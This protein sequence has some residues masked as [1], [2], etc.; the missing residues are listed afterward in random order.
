MGV[1]PS[2]T[3]PVDTATTIT[4]TFPQGVDVSGA[5]VEVAGNWMLG[6][7]PVASAVPGSTGEIVL[8]PQA[9]VADNAATTDVDEAVPAFKIDAGEPIKVEFTA[10]MKGP[11]VGVTGEDE[12]IQ[13]PGTGV[14]EAD[15]T[16]Q[17]VPFAYSRCA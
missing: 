4:I 1:D 14:D 2:A 12:G 17:T 10:P 9:A 16:D 11:T 5:G 3:P 8:T 6:G 15:R 7:K 13:N